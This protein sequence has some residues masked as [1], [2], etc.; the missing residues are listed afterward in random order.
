MKLKVF[1]AT[2]ALLAT[3]AIS[4]GSTSAL[5]I[6]TGP[7][8]DGET[9]TQ[10]DPVVW[11]DADGDIPAPPD[12]GE[13]GDTD[14]GRHNAH[15]PWCG[16]IAEAEGEGSCTNNKAPH[17]DVPL[18]PPGFEGRGLSTLDPELPDLNLGA[19]NAYFLSNDKSA[20][21]GISSV[22]SGG[23]RDIEPC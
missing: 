10:I 17:R 14:V 15:G 7:K 5:E 1:A 20:I 16:N 12:P 11:D 3:M 18:A 21:C 13:Q 8:D 19:W 4:A 6:D 23:H 2:T 22:E 9:K